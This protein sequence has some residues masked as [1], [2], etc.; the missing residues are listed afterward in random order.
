MSQQASNSALI[1]QL[2]HQRASTLAG[3]NGSEESRN[4]VSVPKHDSGL[5]LGTLAPMNRSDSASRSER[6]MSPITESTE[7]RR[8]SN[9]VQPPIDLDFNAETFLNKT[10]TNQ[11]S[12]PDV[13]HQPPFDRVKSSLV[14]HPEAFQAKWD[15]PVSEDSFSSKKRRFKPSLQQHVKVPPTKASKAVMNTPSS[16][17]SAYTESC[18]YDTEG[19][20]SS[21]QARY[22]YYAVASGR[23]IGVFFTWPEAKSQ[24]QGFP[25]SA[26]RGF[27][28]YEEALRYLQGL[29]PSDEQNGH[30][31]P[32][33]PLGQDLHPHD[34]LFK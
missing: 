26:H 34:H 8:Q 28:K 14:N 1:S 10:G 17:K 4:L 31:S 25:G 3:Q 7:P 23:S 11:L 27:H 2:L 29:R 19:S 20:T 18:H 21:H 22:P 33:P 32:R 6:S 12:E 9:D 5:V 13:E 15:P 24:I 30:Q 16:T